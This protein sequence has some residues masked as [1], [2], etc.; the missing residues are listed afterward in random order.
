MTAPEGLARQQID[1]Q[2]AQAGWVIQD[3]ASLN[4]A[5]G[6]G[7]AVREFPLQSGYGFA[8]YLLYVD[9]R[10]IGV[11]EAKKAGTTLTGV[12]LQSEKYGAGLPIGVPAPVRPLPFLYQSTGV[13]TRFTNRLDPVAKS[14]DVFAFHRPDTVTEWLAAE[15]LWLP[16]VNGAPH[17][18]S[19]Q[20]ATFRTRL[21]ALP[22]VDER[23]LWPAQLDAVRRLDQ[24]FAHNRPR[25]LVQMATGS[26]KTFTAVTAST[27][28]SSSPALDGF[29]FSW[30]ARTSVGRRSRSSRATVR[31]TPGG[32]SPRCTTSSA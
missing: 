27:G 28:S 3:V 16:L 6:R 24:S 5:A 30:T 13:E 4:L 22:L 18:R 8:D 26:G 15:P 31:R 21:T 14:R 25:A 7:V 11:V 1:A 29:S 12:E 23:G 32:C 2:L 20:P 17:P 9:G 19:Q 10:A